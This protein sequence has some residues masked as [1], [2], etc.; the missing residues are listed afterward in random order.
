[1][2]RSFQ[3]WPQRRR[4]FAAAALAALTFS[5]VCSAEATSGV[6][7]RWSP[8]AHAETATTAADVE[9]RLGPFSKYSDEYHWQWF[10][11]APKCDP[12]VR[13]DWQDHARTG[14]ILFSANCLACVAIVLWLA[15]WEY[16]D[17]TR[18]THGGM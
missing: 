5:H 1:M 4:S 11:Q 13:V 17:G 9:R 2:P 18:T 14:K 15:T 8:P 6:A 7:G 16:R 10:D 12:N 3:K